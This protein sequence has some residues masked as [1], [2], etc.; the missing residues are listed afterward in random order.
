[1][2]GAGEG[3]VA[4]AGVEQVRVDAGIGVDE[5]AL[6]G[7]ALGA[8]AGDGIAVIKVAML[9]GVE[10]NLPIVVRAGRDAAIGV[11]DSITARSRLAT[12]SDLSGAVNWMRSPAENSRSTSL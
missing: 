12:P 5:D 6:R 9:S 11:I 2:A 7:E 3:D 4:E 1:M 10:L 8:V